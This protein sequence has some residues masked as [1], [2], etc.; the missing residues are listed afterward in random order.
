MSA[1]SHRFEHSQLARFDHRDELLALD[2]GKSLEEI[3]DWFPVR[4]GA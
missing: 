3:F 1:P 4:P 2:R